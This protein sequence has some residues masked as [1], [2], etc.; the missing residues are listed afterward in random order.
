VK[1]HGGASAAGI[2]PVAKIKQ[3][4]APDGRR[5]IFCTFVFLFFPTKVRCDHRYSISTITGQ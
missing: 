5:F 1:N 2:D 3:R 4:A